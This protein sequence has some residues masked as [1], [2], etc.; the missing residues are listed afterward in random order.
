[1][2]FVTFFP[3][4]SL[5]MVLCEVTY[6]LDEVLQNNL[7]P[8][9]SYRLS[10]AS[11]GCFAHFLTLIALLYNTASEKFQKLFF[12]VTAGNLKIL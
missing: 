6:L 3:A 1:M 11:L 9:I 7:E 8:C 5:S 12:F 4:F 10:I 2:F